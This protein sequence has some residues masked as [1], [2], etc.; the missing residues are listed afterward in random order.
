M[1]TKKKEIIYIKLRRKHKK[2]IMSTSKVKK[3]YIY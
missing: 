1:I 2:M 3:N